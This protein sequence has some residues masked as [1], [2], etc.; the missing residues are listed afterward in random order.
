MK[1]KPCPFCGANDP[2]DEGT[3]KGAEAAP[4][5]IASWIE[6]AA[7]K[8]RAGFNTMGSSNYPLGA[9]DKAWTAVTLISVKAWNMRK[10]GKQ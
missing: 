7:C 4:L 10:R 6:C 1:L 3:W 9:V 2:S 5:W 8:A